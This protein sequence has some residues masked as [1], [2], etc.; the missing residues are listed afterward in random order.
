M[1]GLV[2]V[3]RPGIVWAFSLLI[4]LGLL[5][6]VMSLFLQ[7][8]FLSDFGALAAKPVLLASVALALLIVL[9]SIIFLYKFFM[10][11]KSVLPWAYGLFGLYVV[12]DMLTQNWLWLAA[13]LVV[14]WAVV[15]YVS[16]KKVDGTPV[17]T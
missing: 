2:V 14:A 17:F 3:N 15:D 5:S 13:T 4:A 7:S 10:L 12:S 8:K 9:A 16:N 11:Q 6:T 1:G